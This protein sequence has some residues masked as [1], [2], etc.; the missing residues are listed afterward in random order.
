MF[1]A[2]L[3]IDRLRLEDIPD[4]GI[5]LS[6]VFKGGQKDRLCQA[7][8]IDNFPPVR[9]KNSARTKSLGSPRRTLLVFDTAALLAA[10]FRLLQYDFGLLADVFRT[11]F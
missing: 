1:A 8:V 9:V 11:T 3:D 6:T 4:T 5:S 10:R 7:E 2:L